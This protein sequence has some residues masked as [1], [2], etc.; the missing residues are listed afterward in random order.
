M[1]N[2]NFSITAWHRLP[3]WVALCMGEDSAAVGWSL[4]NHEGE[5]F[6]RF[7]WTTP[8]AL[9]G[10]GHYHPLPARADAD[11]VSALAMV[12]L[13]ADDTRPLY[14]PEPDHDG[15]NARGFHIRKPGR[16][17]GYEP[18]LDILPVWATFGK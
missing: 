2:F 18:L 10:G 5:H 15:S 1:D 3:E 7:Y 11:M 17:A 6:I 13:V 16:D 8:N 9:P 4:H 12:R 14:G